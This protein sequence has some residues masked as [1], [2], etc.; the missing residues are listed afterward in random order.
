MVNIWEFANTRPKIKIRTK[1]NA[2]YTGYTL[3][4]W[5]ADESDDDEDSITIEMSSGE[6]KSFYPSDIVSIEAIK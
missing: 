1:N 3:M 2:V 4:V 6:I 5:D